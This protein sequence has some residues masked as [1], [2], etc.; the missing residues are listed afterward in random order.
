MDPPRYRSPEVQP[1]TPEGARAFLDATRGDRL[2]ALY[3]VVLAVGL[4][5]GEALG[6]RWED[7]DVAQ[8]ALKV[9]K[10][11]Q[12]IDGKLQLKDLKNARSKRTRILPLPLSLMAKLKAHRADQ[13]E[14]RLAAGGRWRDSGLVFTSTIGT[15][16][17]ARNVLRRF[18]A[19]TERAGLPRQ[20]FHDLRHC[21]A[22]LL[23]VQGVPPRVVMEILG[24]SDIRL[25]M[26]THAH[27]MPVLQ[28][29]AADMI[30]AFLV[31]Q[32]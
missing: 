8:G 16:L 29:E 28:R 10:Q 14:E 1:F 4:R 12:R 18:Q 6:L 30:E 27:V 22:S 31:G 9:R 25:T 13:L 21:C 3:T 15:P 20:R 5:E 23:L 32:S 11:L 19:L 26:N 17:D 2:E 24:H 7:V